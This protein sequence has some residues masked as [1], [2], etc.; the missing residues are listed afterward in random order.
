MM[1]I[2]MAVL[3]LMN[4]VSLLRFFPQDF[5]WIAA[6]LTIFIPLSNW[7]EKQFANP[8]T[9]VGY[10]LAI[11][12]F[13]SMWLLVFF[14]G[15]AFGLEFLGVEFALMNQVILFTWIIFTILG[16]LYA[17]TWK[18]TKLEVQS[19][20]VK[21]EVKLVHLTDIHAF[22]YWAKDWIKETLDL[23]YQ[24]N[25]DMVLLTGDIIDQPRVPENVLKIKAKVPLLY[26]LG[27]HEYYLGKGVA[28][29]LIK[30]GEMQLLSNAKKIIKGINI[31]GIDDGSHKDQVKKH[32]KG[33]VDKAK[34]NVLMYHRPQGMKA[35]N[36]AG[37]DLM[38]S[39]HT[40]GGV[41]FPVHLFASM[42]FGKFYRGL[43]KIGDLILYTSN[44]SG[45]RNWPLRLFSAQEIV[46]I[47]VRPK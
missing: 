10:R 33:L 38:L 45:T 3:F 28:Q 26:S 32:I 40:H 9:S 24:E 37:V 22:G 4:L 23:A 21:K 44:G 11:G 20:K 46:V 25:P 29:K 47:T 5:L 35:A 27:N 39:G 8:V 17:Q 14:V 30:K 7:F 16:V 12:W 1:V 34:F 36:A 41:N 19:I 13:E 18:I 42:A 15:V 6:A 31:I 43:H 2:M